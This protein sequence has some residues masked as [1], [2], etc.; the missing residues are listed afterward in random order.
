[1]MPAIILV[2][3]GMSEQSSTSRLGDALIHHLRDLAGPGADL[4]IRTVELRPLAHQIVD[5]MTT[6]FASGALADALAAVTAADAL[7]ALTPTYQS[8]YSGLFKSFIDVL[9]TDALA[10]TPVLIGATGGTPRHALVTEVALRPLFTYLHADPVPTAVFAATEDWGASARDSDGQGASLRRRIRRAATELLARLGARDTWAPTD[11]RTPAHPDRPT[12]EAATP[13]SDTGEDHP[14][15]T[16]TYPHFQD[17]ETLL[18]GV[19]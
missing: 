7:I 4:E 19:R 13:S 9:E 5:A 10:G 1:M 8:S 11:P 16:R 18:D 15:A 12:T 2:S 14:S 17:F 6:G 3:A